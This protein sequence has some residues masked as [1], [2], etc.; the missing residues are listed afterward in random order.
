MINMA[1]FKDNG[2]FNQ[3]GDDE[4]AQF[5]FELL[6]LV[7]R[8]HDELDVSGVQTL[9]SNLKKLVGDVCAESITIKHKEAKNE[10]TENREE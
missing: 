3:R 6:R 9:E 10:S 8:L 2:F 7:A 5:R 4:A 1:I